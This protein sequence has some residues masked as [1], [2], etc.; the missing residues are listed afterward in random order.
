LAHG[1]RFEVSVIGGMNRPKN[2]NLGSL[3]LTTPKDDDVKFIDHQPGLG[4][5][6]T[7]N[8]RGYYGHELSYLRSRVLLRTTVPREAGD[9]VQEDW[10]YLQRLAYNFLIYFMPAG[11]RWRPFVTGGVHATRYPQGNVPEWT[12]G[13][14]RNWGFNYGGGIKL[15]PIRHFQIRLDIR[16][17]LNGKPYDLAF[18]A[19]GGGGRLKHLIATAG[20]GF[21]F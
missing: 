19:L 12:T 4:L 17:D 18:A 9:F 11:E 5:A 1:Q 6:L 14:S 3:D 8:T 10:L 2:S 7:W 16:Q 15:M 20:A 21:T 13:N